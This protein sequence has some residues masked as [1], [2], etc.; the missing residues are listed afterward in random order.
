MSALSSNSSSIQS[1]SVIGDKE[2]KKLEKVLAQE[3]KADQKAIDRALE[4]IRQSEKAL[5]KCTQVRIKID[6]NLA[7]RLNDSIL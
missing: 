7:E 2:A 1:V 3:A 5:Q 6:F 4:D